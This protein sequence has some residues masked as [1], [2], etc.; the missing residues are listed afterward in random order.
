MFALWIT[1][2]E[3][4]LKNVNAI[5][6]KYDPKFEYNSVTLGKKLCSCKVLFEYA[7]VFFYEYGKKS[8]MDKIHLLRDIITVKINMASSTNCR[9]LLLNVHQEQR[10]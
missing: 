10:H 6:T 5:N 1:K 9:K 3:R 2:R 8:E 4:A 7:T